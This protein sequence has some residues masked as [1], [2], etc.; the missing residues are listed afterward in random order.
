MKINLR[1]ASVIDAHIREELSR[2]NNRP[3]KVKVNLYDP[4]IASQVDM[5]GQEFATESELYE[6]LLEARQELRAKVAQRNVEVGVHALLAEDACLE[7]KERRLKGFQGLTSR[8]SEEGIHRLAERTL[9]GEHYS[10]EEMASLDFLTAGELQG[11]K[12]KLSEVA[13]RRRRLKD[14]MIA[15][16]VQSEL[17]LSDRTMKVLSEVG[18][19]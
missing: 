16:N 3:H 11:L 5:Y 18:L 12:D 8:L 13:R 19:D 10:G 17:T 7:L 4:D 14:E 6:R 9:S 2:L 15:L 1:K